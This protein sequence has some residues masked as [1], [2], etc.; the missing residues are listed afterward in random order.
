V[1]LFSAEG[2]LQARVRE[3]DRGV[4]TYSGVTANAYLRWLR[5]QG[6]RVHPDLPFPAS[7]CAI[8]SCATSSRRSPRISTSSPNGG[9]SLSRKEIRTNG[10][11]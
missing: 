5:T 11:G 8:W 2:L 9:E 6:G 10:S 4:T 1:T 7:G 3:L